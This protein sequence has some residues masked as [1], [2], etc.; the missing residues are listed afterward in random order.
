MT[1]LASL[2]SSVESNTKR[3]LEA[4]GDAASRLSHA[5]PLH[6]AIDAEQ[7]E[8]T[9]HGGQSLAYYVDRKQ[10]GERPL[11]LIHSVN[12]AASSYE[13]RPLFE[14]FRAT[15]PTYA[16][17]LPGFGRSGRDSRPYTI[18]LYVEAVRELLAR[19]KE[20]DGEADVV[21]LSLGGEFAARVAA[22]HK[23]LVHTLTL[24][25]PT[26]FGRASRQRSS[27]EPV[28]KVIREPAVSRLLF[29]LVA[30][31]PS[32]AYF[33]RKS[34]VGAPDPGLVSY[35][36]ATSHQPGAYRAPMA[37]LTGALF[38][39]NVR[40]T[41][42]ARV[43]VPTLVVHD[44]DGYATFDALPAFAAAHENWK[45]QRVAPTKGMPQFEQ[46]SAFAGTLDDFWK[47][48]LQ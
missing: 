37:F 9:T 2:A 13:M 11:V 43:A 45:V 34:F 32:I 16:L 10:H 4:V 3:V 7:K 14:R 48:R 12:A 18:D 44:R 30:S 25:S 26:G 46:L 1:A 20:R 15:R 5:A 29:E 42:Y 40:E 36:H 19:V 21:A 6:P 38:S 24:V 47:H 23:D 8:M 27:F 41:V 31:R 35:A 22:T 39:E 33:L 17:D 28:K